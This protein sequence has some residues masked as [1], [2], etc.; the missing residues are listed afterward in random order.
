MSK[1]SRLFF[2]INSG[3]SG[4]HYLQKL[5]STSPE[6][7]SFGEQAPTMSGKY[8]H[9]VNKY[10]YSVSYD[11]R[12]IKT[13]KIENIITNLP[14]SKL[15]YSE[16]NHM[17][18]KTFFDVVIDHFGPK[19]EVIIL[20][21]NLANTLKSFIELDYLGKNHVSYDWMVNTDSPTAATRALG[22]FKQMSHYNRCIAYLLDIE[23][24]ALRF[25]KDYPNIKTHE[26]RVENL[27]DV[28]N[29]KIFFK[30]LGISYTKETQSVLGNAVNTRQSRKKHFNN[31][32][33]VD[34]CAKKCRQYINRAK[35]AGIDVPNVK[36]I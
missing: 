27:N 12:K 32:T 29:V 11:D 16:T 30:Q 28:K 1:I 5:L 17:F 3:R 19:V 2:C 22:K 36:I 9:A 13:D 18:I 6:I 24:R 4:S 26:V 8:L 21:R 14:K 31:I 35:V 7:A 25:Q 10:P 15:V 34:L 20:R 23:A 33:T